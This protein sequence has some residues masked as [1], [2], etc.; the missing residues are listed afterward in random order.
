MNEKAKFALIA[1]LL[2]STPATAMLPSDAVRMAAERDPQ[3]AAARAAFEADAEAGEQER[4]RLRPQLAAVGTGN[5]QRSDSEFAFGSESDT[6]PSWSAYLRARQPLLRLDWSA[7]GDRAE[8]RDALAQENLDQRMQQFVARVAQRYLGVLL[9]EDAVEQA[10]SAA[11]AVR[12]SLDDTRKRYE[13]ELVPGTDL[14][15]AQARDDLAQAELVSA[16]AAL[17]EARDALQEI[18][19]YDRARLPRMREDVAFPATAPATIEEWLRIAAERST[20]LTGARLRL[21]VARTEVESRRAEALPSMDLVAEA[22]RNDSREYALGQRQDDVRVGVELNVP[23]YAGGLNRSRVREAEA[24]LREAQAELDRLALETEREVRVRFRALQTARARSE[25]YRI[26]LDSATL[27]QAAARAG[28]DAGTRT[29]TDVIDAQSRVVQAR[30][31]RNAARYDL[32][33][34]SVLL[35]AAAGTLE[36]SVLAQ[37]DALFESR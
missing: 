14:K 36:P 34:Q 7:R 33:T 32:L 12:K 16:R 37:S 11:E 23:I 30:R 2:A 17:E 6:F 35:N 22:G 8:A 31:N 10:Q 21:D 1:L 19:G 25:A 26:A 15:E 27:A 20:A 5:Y 13:V 9:A 4:A 24:R 18:T 3:I 29:I 28:Y